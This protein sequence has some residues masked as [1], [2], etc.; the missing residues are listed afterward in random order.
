MAFDVHPEN[1]IFEADLDPYGAILLSGAFVAFHH[2]VSEWY[3]SC[4]IA[5]ERTFRAVEYLGGPD[6]DPCE[7]GEA[8]SWLLLFMREEL[9]YS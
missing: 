7:S 6:G 5:C 1:L 9:S 2:D 3:S 4:I 8:A